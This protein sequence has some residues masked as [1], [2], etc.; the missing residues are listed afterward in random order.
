MKKWG[1]VSNA[2]AGFGAVDR[3]PIGPNRF[4]IHAYHGPGLVLFEIS[5]PSDSDRTLVDLDQ[6]STSQISR[7]GQ[8]LNVSL[9]GGNWRSGKIQQHIN[10]R[11]A[12]SM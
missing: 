1:T 10:C 3:D 7:F 5:K 2:K 8:V 6:I 11:K 9:V 12:D 4:V